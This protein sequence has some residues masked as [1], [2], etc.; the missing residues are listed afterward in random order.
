[1]FNNIRLFYKVSGGFF[2]I[3]LL[4]GAIGVTAIYTLASLSQ[5][6]E[7]SDRA[8][9]SITDLQSLSADREAFL[10]Q[11]GTQAAADVTASLG[12]LE[13]TLSG[14]AA[15]LAGDPDALAS[16]EA[17]RTKVAA[18]GTTFAAVRADSQA[19]ADK[20]KVVDQATAQLDSLTRTIGNE[21]QRQQRD[22]AD[23]SVLAEAAQ[24]DL[25]KLGRTGAELQAQIDLLLPM[26]GRGSEFKLGDITPELRAQIEASLAKI[27]ADTARLAGSRLKVLPEADGVAMTRTAET[28][29]TLL[30]AMLDET[31]LFNRMGQKKDVADRL[32]SLATQTTDA[33]F[34]IYA[35][36]DEALNASN[37]MQQKLADLTTIGQQALAIA[38][39]IS[40]V[41]N[42]TTSFLTGMGDV[43]P[44][45]VEAEIDMLGMHAMQLD[46]ASQHVPAAAD[47]IAAMP[48]AL[49]TYAA[50][51]AAIRTAKA[52][53]ETNRAE[54]DRLTLAL[55]D[56]ATGLARGQSAANRAAGEMAVTTIAVAVVAAGLLGLGL[57]F[58]LN[59][60]ITRPIRSMTATMR[61]L[62]TG[63]T[64][65][66]VPGLDRAD[67][68]G[69]MGRAV[70]V[71]KDNALERMRLEARTQTET[72]AQRRRQETI[73][74][75]IA[76]FRTT[77]RD[78][79]GSV[80]GT[81]Q[82]LGSTARSLTD[83]AKTSALRAD[84]AETAAGAATGS[85]D[86]VAGA[87]EQLAASINEI[88]EQVS[89]TT[90][91]VN[92]ATVGT[93]E[94]NAKVASLAAAAEKIGEVVTLIQSIAAQTNLLALNA[95]IE[96]ARAGEAGRGFAV[97][98][99][100]VKELAN[101]TSRATE[102]IST[103]I[104]AIQQATEDSAHA[105]GEITRV[106]DQVND[107]TGSIASAV[108]EQSAATSNISQN[109]RVAAAGTTSVSSN[110]SVLAKA[111]DETAR[112]AEMVLSASSDLNGKTQHLRQEVD[113]FLSAVAAA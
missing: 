57:A 86:S 49:D 112:S 30:P 12:A 56:T 50:A 103:Q 39:S 42:G 38:S 93:R 36:L 16:V 41:K 54:L 78:L 106:M 108:T 7:I 64:A 73:E 97:V 66:E 88:G 21:L 45:A 90:R 113:R 9:T 33:R 31:N 37:L 28:L 27:N 18:F 82:G 22:A 62:A 70:Q 83:I 5:R 20:L 67:E 11:P 10:R 63:D 46:G 15:K 25:R 19:V 40:T 100:E 65:T 34:K 35:A 101:Q 104:S 85:V 58:S 110:V 75:L 89:R 77:A 107:Y 29:G 71:F 43:A 91:I 102:D 79:I 105:I 2:S 59:L 94:T 8:L 6:S 99:A 76:E 52:D 44:D 3:L 53:L 81:A 14:L 61:R 60:A 4:M 84:E 68:I 48:Q 1:M 17:A 26:F 69:D 23:A 87:A 111:V 74:R 98:A 13:T 24:N 51:F 92:E 80:E 55:Q 47:A 95:T 72:E 32:A 109:V 96:A